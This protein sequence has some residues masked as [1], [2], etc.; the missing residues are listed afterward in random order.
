[1]LNVA[2]SLVIQ[3]S[4]PLLTPNYVNING[5]NGLKVCRALFKKS[6]LDSSCRFSFRLCL[7]TWPIAPAAPH[8]LQES[9]HRNSRV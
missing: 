8:P 5:E 7:L 1:M 6:A 9:H 2:F 3:A 4:V